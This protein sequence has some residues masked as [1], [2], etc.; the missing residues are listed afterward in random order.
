MWDKQ[1]FFS[2]RVAPAG[3]LGLGRDLALQRSLWLEDGFLGVV[4]V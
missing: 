2:V 3:V 1:G 4:E